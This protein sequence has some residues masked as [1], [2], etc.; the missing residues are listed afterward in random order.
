MKFLIVYERKN[1]EL[2][3]AALLKAYLE[4]R[5][6]EC[7]ISQF[8]EAKKFNLLGRISY[9][10]ILVPHCY[11][12]KSIPRVFSRFGKANIYNLQYEQVLSNKWEELGHHNPS[13]EAIKATHM[14]W[15]KLTEQRLRSFGIP[16]NNLH[17]MRPLHLD[18]LDQKLRFSLDKRKE[19]SKQY[20]LD[21]TKK[22]NLFLSSFT[23]ADI[24]NERLRMNENVAGTS[25]SSFKTI[26]TKSRNKLLEWFEDVLISDKETILIYRPHPD[27]LSLN[28]ITELEKKYENFFVINDLAVKNWI[29]ICDNIFSWYSTSV[30]EAHFLN[31]EY[32]VLRPYELPNSFDSVLIKKAKFIT[33]LSEFKS[34]YLGCKSLD[35][36]IEDKYINGYY[37]TQQSD[38]SCRLLTEKIEKLAQAPFQN[39]KINRLLKI[40]A[41][42]TTNF[43]YVTYLLYS[44]MPLNLSK[45]RS[46]KR[47]SNN[48]LIKWF[49]EFDN[50]I[51]SNEEID[52]L[53]LRMKNLLLNISK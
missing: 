37:N 38:L 41:L 13:G 36:A 1:R 50:Q 46:S 4:I 12:D 25:L 42:F 47:L 6:H 39:F 45:Y 15:G 17:L 3:N 44:K 21:N 10:V 40:K 18:L 8:Y 51:V 9:D 5:G 14:C 49:I 48:F 22:W 24:E 35:F 11:G 32:G 7:T 2:E 33:S 30:V 31:K 52:E 19:L 53:T 43:V 29:A 26:H 23:Y 27:E 34:Y 28:K 16:N 20:N